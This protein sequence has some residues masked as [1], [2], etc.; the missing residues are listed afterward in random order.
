MVSVSDLLPYPLTY[1][2]DDWTFEP[3]QKSNALAILDEALKAGLGPRGG[4]I[5]VATAMQESTLHNVP[6]G[7]RTSVGLFQQ[8]EWW[9]SFDQRMDPH[10]SSWKFF[11]EM[12]KI[13]PPKF[14]AG[15]L[16]ST[17]LWE[18]AQAVQVSGYPTYYAKHE[19]AAAQLVAELYNKNFDDDAPKRV[20]LARKADLVLKRNTVTAIP[21]IDEYSDGGN[22]HPDKADPAFITG[23]SDYIATAA[24]TLKDVAPGL[25]VQT[26][27]NELNAKGETVKEGPIEEHPGT[28]GNTYITQTRAGA[29]CD[30]GNHVVWTI[31][32]INGDV[33]P[34]LTYAEVQ[35]NYWPR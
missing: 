15:Y 7:D 4:V 30:P 19:R 5:G 18:V 33:D 22:Q 32:I 1:K 13:C 2:Q 25:T 23:N 21:F 31:E 16:T 34:T 28:T 8:Q 6:G 17:Q 35:A 24:A 3:D 20:S 14:G 11:S 9:G 27:F 26:R 29:V 10:W 12:K